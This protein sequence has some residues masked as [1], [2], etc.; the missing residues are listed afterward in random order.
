MSGLID[1]DV[2]AR[3][4]L[5]KPRLLNVRELQAELCDLAREGKRFQSQNKQRKPYAHVQV[6]SEQSVG[7]SREKAKH[8]L[9]L[10]ELTE[11]L[12]KL[13]VNQEEQIVKFAHLESR[14]VTTP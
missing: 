3:I 6:A 5:M 12:R 13:A 14:M 10:S 7:T 2:Y 11:M 8:A 4:A 1:E 9:D